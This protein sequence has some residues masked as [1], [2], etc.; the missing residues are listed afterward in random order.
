MFND[1][2]PTKKVA[3]GK[4]KPKGKLIFT[5]LSATLLSVN[6]IVTTAVKSYYYLEN[7]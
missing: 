6:V 1:G 7:F 2:L 3:I 4:R 5:Y